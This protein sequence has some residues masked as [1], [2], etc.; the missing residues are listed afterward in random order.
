MDLWQDYNK[1]KFLWLG[2]SSPF[3]ALS[4]LKNRKVSSKLA[5]GLLSVAGAQDYAAGLLLQFS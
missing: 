3:S 1:I 4:T 2:D 5:V